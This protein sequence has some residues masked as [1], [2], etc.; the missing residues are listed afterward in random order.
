MTFGIGGWAIDRNAAADAGIDAVHVY[1]F[2][3]PGSGAP[4]MFVGATT[5]GLSR[6]DVAAVFG[7][8][9]ANAG[10][11][12]EGRTLA[13]GSYLLAA[14][15]RSLATGAFDVVA[16][17]MVTVPAPVPQPIL[18]VD[19]PASGAVVPSGAPLATTGW[20]IDRGAV[21]GTGMDAIHVWIFPS[22]GA[23]FFGGVATYG[24]SRPD[25]GAIFGAPFTASGYALNVTGLTP[26]TYVIA[27]C[28]HSTVTNT[29]SA[30]LTRTVT[31]Q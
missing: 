28:A 23:P 18:I 26:G 30:I 24:A 5:V 20:A 12:I 14:L 17:R 6:P 27:V 9:F 13:P 11:G 19:A 25:V 8:Q 15:A 22:S 1:A 3:N 10:W 16:T 7:A 29:F 21:T 4:P 31:I 2:P